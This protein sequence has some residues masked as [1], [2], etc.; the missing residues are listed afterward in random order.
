[1]VPAP[2]PLTLTE[3]KQEPAAGRFN[4]VNPIVLLPALAEMSPPQ[5]PVKLFGLATTRPAGIVSLAET[6]INVRL[7]FGLV[8]VKVSEVVSFNGMLA[9][10]NA[11]PIVGGSGGAVTVNVAVLLVVPG[12]LSVE[13]IG[14]VVLLNVPRALGACTFTEIKHVPWAGV[15]NA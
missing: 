10:P 5:V 7:E 12:S 6:F 2:A 8:N 4:A 1:M 14:P 3:K 15:S 13:V 11:L 9:A